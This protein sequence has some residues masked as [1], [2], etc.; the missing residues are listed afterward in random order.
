MIAEAVLI[1][2]GPLIKKESRA[3]SAAPFLLTDTLP[4]NHKP[5]IAVPSFHRGQPPSVKSVCP[6]YPR[7]RSKII[8]G[9]FDSNRYRSA[10]P[11]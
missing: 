5:D 2:E 7:I 3:K 11:Y 4:Q 10:R 9:H 1:A 6:G 8:A